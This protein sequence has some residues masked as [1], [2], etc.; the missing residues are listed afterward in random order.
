LAQQIFQ[1]LLAPNRARHNEPVLT[2]KNP[3]FSKVSLHLIATIPFRDFEQPPIFRIEQSASRAV[4]R[5]PVS[6]AEPLK[7]RI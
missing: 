5:Q 4:H 3:S 7:S 2:Q 1:A 6:A